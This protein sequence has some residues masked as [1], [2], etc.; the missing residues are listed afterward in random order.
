MFSLRLFVL[1]DSLVLLT[2]DKYIIVSIMIGRQILI[3]FVNSIN[4][5][6][7]QSN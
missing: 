5:N 4:L 2:G 1:G 7:W 3:V 6:I